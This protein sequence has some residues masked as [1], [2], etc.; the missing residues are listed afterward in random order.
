MKKSKD[1]LRADRK[2]FCSN[3]AGIIRDFENLEIYEDMKKP[4]VG[5]VGKFW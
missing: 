2:T 3:I 4:R 5:V 1:I